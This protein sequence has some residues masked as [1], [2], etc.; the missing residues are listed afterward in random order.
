M[1]VLK[2]FLKNNRK[3]MIISFAFLLLLV[4]PCAADGYYS[5]DFNDMSGLSSYSNVAISGGVI[6]PTGVLSGMAEKDASTL[7]YMKMDDAI[8]GADQIIL[9]NASAP[10]LNSYGVDYGLTTGNITSS[11]DAV[12]GGSLAFDGTGTIPLPNVFITVDQVRR[13]GITFSAW[14]K[15]YNTTGRNL[16][17]GSQLSGYSSPGLYINEGNLGFSMRYIDSSNTTKTAIAKS[18]VN[19]AVGA[20]HHV[21]ATYDPYSLNI[22]TYLDGTLAASQTIPTPNVGILETAVRFI[23][24]QGYH[25]GYLEFNG[26]MDEVYVNLRPI[27]DQEAADL[28]QKRKVYGSFESNLIS[29]GGTFNTLKLTSVEGNAGTAQVLVNTGSGWRRITKN[30]DLIYQ[31]PENPPFSSFRYKV[32]FPANSS[33]DSIRFDWSSVDYVGDP[34]SIVFL[35]TSDSYGGLEGYV[36]QA[37]NVTLIKYPELDFMIS[38]GDFENLDKI[39]SAFNANFKSLSIRAGLPVPAP[40]FTVLGNHNPEVMTRMDYIVS[41]MGPKLQAQ[42]PGMESFNMGPY[43]F[44]HSWTT[45]SFDYKNAHFIFINEYYN[46]TPYVL[47]PLACVYDDIYNWLEQDLRSATKPIKFVFAHEAAF[48][49]PGANH[50]GDSLDDSRCPNNYITGSNPA[51]PARDRYWELLRSY[52]VVAHF[53][54]HSHVSSHI[55]VQNLTSSFTLPNPNAYCDTDTVVPFIQDGQSL[56]AQD[57]VVEFD[58]GLTLNG[59]YQ[60]IKVNGN[61]ITFESYVNYTL[62]KTFTYQVGPQCTLPGDCAPRECM[63]A[64]CT[65]GQCVY[66]NN[67]GVACNDGNACTQTDICSGG[68]CTGGN[69]VICNDGFFCTDDSCNPTNGSCSYAP[70]DN[71]CG[72]GKYCSPGTPGADANGCVTPPGGRTFFVDRNL[73]SNCVGSYN[74]SSRACS[75]GSYDAYRTLT[76]GA[77]AASSGDTVLI[78]AG[79][80]NEMLKPQNSGVNG[81]PIV[82]R[83]YNAES[84]I[85]TGMP[86]LASVPSGEDPDQIGRQLC[87]YIWGK[88]YIEIDG[89][90]CINVQAWARIVSSDHIT[91]RNSVFNG[92]SVPG[93]Q[94]GINF[95]M[96]D[97]NKVLNNQIHDGNDNLVFIDSDRNLVQGNNI[98]KGRHT[99]WAIVCGNYN[100]IR[101]NYFHN[102]LQKIGEIYDCSDPVYGGDA[103]FFNIFKTDST[104]RN[105]IE[106]NKFA[107]TPPAIASDQLSGIQY[108]GQNGIIRRNLFY[109]ITGIPF[110]LT[111]YADEAKY[112]WGNRVYNNDFYMNHFAGI[113]MTSGTSYTFTDNVM[114]NNILFRNDFIN[115]DGRWGT[116][117]EAFNGSGVQV[118][119]LRTSDFV[120]DRNDIINQVPGEDKLIGHGDGPTYHTLSWWQANYPAVFLNNAE[121]NPQFTDPNSRIFHLFSNSTLIDSGTYLTRAAATGSGTSLRVADAS[122]FYDGYGISGEQ[123]DII[124]LEGSSQTARVL[125]IDYATNTLSLDRSLS[126]SSNQGVG[127]AYKAN[128]PDIG[129]MEYF[130]GSRADSS[131]NWCIETP[132]LLNFIDHWKTDSTVYKLVELMG[133]IGYWKGGCYW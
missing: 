8:S 127:L 125:S 50:C 10:G 123:G 86:G 42:L 56:S 14:V 129:T 37:V 34:N 105:L 39:D 20:W 16:I 115:Y 94:G 83:A 96:S 89:I 59:K 63:T 57:G 29:T 69:P 24:G 128:G 66:S 101:G 120:F 113:G 76:E 82:F 132:E 74:P 121:V 52:G 112:T 116:D 33:I 41:K 72:V 13:D 55:I 109:D 35:A 110:D 119:T 92:A 77:N 2:N 108:A 67:D 64:S 104:K 90:Q 7:I 54:G 126:W 95:I 98:T 21:I 102:E 28:F 133:A 122:Y 114:K 131:Q 100:V 27:Y 32:I 84:V 71:N 99:I 5:Y 9:N 31:T 47:N 46:A 97:Y 68:L 78:R 36:R 58:D 73:A 26:L 75:G 91:L 38:T 40:W 88:R 12:F 124:Q 70:N 130:P 51:R 111:L 87:I 22:R 103:I 25:S 18:T 81:A 85:L 62:N 93:R 44:G 15:P 6:R 60:I 53:V 117:W 3:T 118:W 61:T 49:I 43:N 48:P 79:T 107:Y 45:Y 11:S 23:V 65:N 80:Y 30:S 17:I 19:I 106:R 1:T 4:R